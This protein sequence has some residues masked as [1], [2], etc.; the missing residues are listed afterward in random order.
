MS[1]V[2]WCVNRCDTPCGVC[3]LC[4]GMPFMYLNMFVQVCRTVYVF[5]MQIC[6][7]HSDLPHPYYAFLRVIKWEQLCLSCVCICLFVDIKHTYLRMFV[8]VHL[9]I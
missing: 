7:A 5:R 4:Q 8:C 2:L 6:N 3:G 1:G 9:L